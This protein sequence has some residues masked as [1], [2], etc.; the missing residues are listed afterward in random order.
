[1]PEHPSTPRMMPVRSMGSIRLEDVREN[2]SKERLNWPAVTRNA[3]WSQARRKM[4]RPWARPSVNSTDATP[5]NTGL[6]RAEAHSL[7]LLRMNSEPG[8]PSTDVVLNCVSA[9]P[10]TTTLSTGARVENSSS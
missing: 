6:R 3:G 4:Y 9:R 1:M 8:S 5:S 10:P 7:A 2:R